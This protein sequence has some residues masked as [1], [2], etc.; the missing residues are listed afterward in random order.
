MATIDDCGVFL[1]QH[2][3]TPAML[4]S[5]NS[6]ISATNVTNGLVLDLYEFMNKHRSRNYDSFRRWLALLMG[7]EW[8]VKTFP[9][10][11]SLRQSVIRLSS[12][13]TK[14]KKERN[15]QVKDALIKGFLCESYCLPKYMI[16]G[17]LHT[18]SSSS[19]NANSS[20]TSHSCSELIET[21][22]KIIK[23]TREKCK[24]SKQRVYSI[25]RN[26]RKKVLRREEE[27]KNKKMELTEKCKLVN[28]LE[29]R[30]IEAEMTIEEL[31]QNVDRVRRRVS[32]W[33]VKCSTLQ[34]LNEGKELELEFDKEKEQLCLQEEITRL[35]QENSELR[36]T[37][38]ELVSEEDINA[39]QDGKYTDDVRV[40]CYELLS[41]NVG[42]Q[43][44]R[45]VI[46]SVLKNIAHKS[47]DRLPRNTALCDMM[48][49]SLTIAQAQLADQLTKEEC[50][51]LTLQTDGTTKYGQ[52]FST[53]DIA[54]DSAVYHLGLRH[55]F[56]GSAQS[57]LD[58][59]TEILD[60]LNIVS[61]E[62]GSNGVSQKLVMKLK[63]TMSD[64]H[65]AEKLFSQLLQEYR[66]DILPDV[67]SG[68]DE[69][70][71]DEKHV[72]TRMNNFYC[73]LHFIVGLADTAESVLK[74]WESTIC[75]V[76]DQGRTSGTQR[77]IR[78]ACKAFHHKGSEQAGCSV[79]FRTY[80]RGNGVTKIPLAA[81]RGNR[82]NIIF[83]DAAGIY[84]LKS[85]MEMY[86]LQ[87]HHSALNRLLQAVLSD[88]KVPQYIA[89]VKAL[90]IIDKV[91]TGPF[92]RYLE[93][94]SVSILKMSETYSKMKEKFESW[95]M[96]AQV[97][98]EAN[99]LLFP[100]Y[101]NLDDPVFKVLSQQSSDDVMVE[102]I[103]QL[104]FKSFALTLQRLVIDH[105]P[106]GVYNS[107]QDPQIVV[108][109]KSVPV[110]NVTPERDFA[111]LDRLMSQKP[112]ASYI[113]IESLLLFSHNKTS[114]WL[115]NKASEEKK[116]LLNAARTLT[117]VHKANFHKRRQE[118]EVKRKE[119]F[120]SK[121]RDRRKKKEK[122]IKE[123]ES[124]TKQI[125]SAGLW[126][127][128][129]E[130]HKGLDKMRTKKEKQD[131]LKLQIKFRKRVLCQSTD[132]QAVF[133]FSH[134]HKPFTNSEL[135]HNLFKLLS[136]DNG[137]SVLT[138]R[139]VKEDP[140]LLIYRR[141]EHR[142]NCDGKL[143]WYKGT[144][145]GFNKVTNEFRILYD[146]EEEE[147]T[148]QLLEDLERDDLRIVG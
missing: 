34:I 109:T 21:D 133:H 49:E 88:L 135:L 73:G 29:K 33:K 131:A 83:Y 87:H 138:S 65:S 112:N 18:L 50:D 26:T 23:E 118:I 13:L 61:K 37:V 64:R 137:Q 43:N 28:H 77:L 95:S 132:D 55:I 96:D 142:F 40:C 12:R 101:T 51:Y 114:E 129:E 70:S 128:K 79:R 84:Y 80:C 81:F 16:H 11:K 75:E 143:L 139:D 74:A 45:A 17:K 3:L 44:I 97:V 110:T 85:H 86:L 147:C 102:E 105:L 69:M 126:T 4:L 72:L 90:G 144:V 141:V 89:G 38:E 15:S 107:V 48:V 42:I 30:L 98:M 5:D 6:S 39:Y 62:L 27:I 25:H 127:T 92:W 68:W 59:F 52:H 122:E 54:T 58:V 24:E 145:L 66:K 100:D 46:T 123:K 32:Y 121:E 36:D 71:Q 94:S 53:Y 115:E 104:L 116:R 60:D 14:I 106:G 111:V 8:P 113:A 117:S 91:V 78:T 93:S 130:V 63:N 22:S 19:S 47:I 9:T 56:S 99:E 125:S 108:E 2:G 134:N 10:S 124:L 7:Y 35:E 41:L 103:L 67:V 148:F 31:K 136:L 119:I 20:S 57:T 120:E 76:G 140:E 82:F 1:L 146:D